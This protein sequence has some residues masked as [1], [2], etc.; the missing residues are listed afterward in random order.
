MKLFGKK[1]EFIDKLESI[2]PRLYRLAYSWCHQHALADDLVQETLTKALKYEAQLKELKKFD[3]WVFAILTNNWR[4]HLS[5][6]KIMDNIDDHIFVDTNT[7]DKIV[8]QA[9]LNT[10]VHSA[11]ET[12]SQGQRQ[13]IT[14]IDLEGFSYAEASEILDIPIGTVMSRISRARNALADKLFKTSQPAENASSFMW[15]VK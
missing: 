13:V 12:L 9:Q 6:T 8:E 10:F 11:I 14:L 15:R 3:S 2:R 7:P 5:R 1:R 4:N